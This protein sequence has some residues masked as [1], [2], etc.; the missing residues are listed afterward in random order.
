M[1]REVLRSGDLKCHLGEVHFQ[2]L[3]YECE[4]C[5]QKFSTKVRIKTHCLVECGMEKN[6]FRTFFSDELD[7]KKQQIRECMA[8][9]FL[10]E[11]VDQ[12]C[13]QMQSQICVPVADQ[14]E[15]DV[16]MTDD[17]VDQ[18]HANRTTS[19]IDGG[20]EVNGANHKGDVDSLSSESSSSYRPSTKSE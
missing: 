7:S 14:T 13:G 15:S 17:D 16:L 11:G 4:I 18:V 10:K 3:P 8:K 9:Y 19:T 20:V 12:L 5:S 2:Y 1:S 6:S